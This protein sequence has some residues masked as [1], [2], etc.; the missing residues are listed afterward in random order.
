MKAYPQ[1]VYG[2]IRDTEKLKVVRNRELSWELML[3]GG[4][5]PTKRLVTL[6]LK[7]FE[8]NNQKLKE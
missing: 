7:V 5:L 1:K 6:A 8:D 4:I 3:V 2:L